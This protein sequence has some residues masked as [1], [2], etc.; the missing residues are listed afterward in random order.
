MEAEILIDA[1]SRVAALNKGIYGQFIEHLG[2]CIYGGVWVGPTSRIPNVKGF[3]LDVLNAVREIRPPIVRWPG[4]N[5]ASSYHWEDGIGP[6]ERR[7]RRFELAWEAEEPNEFGTCEFIEWA[8][9]VGAEPFIVVNAGNGTPEEAAR[10]VE[11]CNSTRNTHYA[12]LRR[13][14]G[15][16]EPFKVKLW[17]VGNELYGSWQVGFCEDGEECARRTIEFVNE[18]KRVDRT[19]E[20]VA[21]G[22]DYDPQWN[23]DMVRV[24]GNYFDYLSVH[25]YIFTE[26]QGRSY[27]ELV[28]WPVEIE[29]WL[30]A[31]YHTVQAA[32]RRYG[33]RKDIKLAFDEWNV[34]YPEARPPLLSQNTAVRDA[35]FTALVL[36]AL[37][38]LSRIVPIA[39]FAQTVNVLPLILT[40][41][42]GRILLTPQYF[43]FKLYSSVQEGDV[44]RTVCF[45]PS[46]TSKEVGTEVQYVDASAVLSGGKLHL[47]VVNRHPD[48]R[49]KARVFI[50]GFEPSAVHHRWISGASVDDRNTF[51]EPSR[52]AISETSYAF[53]GFV[54]LP[55]HSV[56]VLTLSPTA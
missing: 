10:W 32:K 56:N 1:T 19:I 49:V 39:C 24:A 13:Q 8:R 28:A 37:Q 30:K 50:R 12:N 52:V 3:R 31:T 23:I 48:E 15:Y 4:G 43:I 26:H 20:I 5:F 41:D 25:R 14:L 2:R 42:E 34:W 47:F 36:N 55:P 33:I 21:V 18:M 22:C 54:E 35:I 53:K 27:E 9:M 46:Y 44:V 17:G 51:E 16:S 45:S 38:R 40:D 11:F 6:R 29:E 7:P